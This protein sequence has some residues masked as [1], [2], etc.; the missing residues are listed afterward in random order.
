MSRLICGGN[1]ISGYA[2]SRDLIYVSRLLKA[3]F[4]DEKVMETW[5]I[6][7]RHG[8]NT[9]IMNPSD[10]RALELYRTYRRNGGRIQYIAQ[11]DGQPNGMDRCIEEAVESEAIAMLLVGNLGDKW[12]REGEAGIAQIRDFVA[13]VQAHGVLAGVAGHEIRTAKVCEAA[14]I[15]PD[16]YMKTLHGNQ[17]FSAR[18][19][20]Q[21]K[22]VI[23]NYA[24]DNY[25]CKDAEET[26]EFMASVKRPWLAYKVLAAG[27]IRP[28]D[29]FR[30]AFQSGADFCVVGMFDFQIT[31][32][33]VVA[34]EVLA[35][36]SG[37]TRPWIA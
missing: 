9:M 23:D 32:D 21:T 10:R 17:Y 3:Y 18:R 30:Y 4:T 24:V 31:E 11:L 28:R 29:G 5:A 35:Q 19:P 8:I 26:I 36:L 13:K 1:L 27:A 14:G 6:C 7:E 2:H 37:R 20:D 34:N 12:S 25:W 22:D 16:F 33:V 15:A